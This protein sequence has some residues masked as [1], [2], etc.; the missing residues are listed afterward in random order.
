MNEK[1]DCGAAHF[2][3]W[4]HSATDYTE[5]KGPAWQNAEIESWA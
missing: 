4:P 1:T 5:I 2:G 3:L